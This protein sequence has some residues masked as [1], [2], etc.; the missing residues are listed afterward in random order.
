MNRKKKRDPRR[1]RPV[2][3]DG[4]NPTERRILLYLAERF[5]LAN[6]RWPEPGDVL[7]V[8]ENGDEII[9]SAGPFPSRP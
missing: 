7:M 3:A 1:R 2:D 6:G 5:E 9:R 8:D 4:L